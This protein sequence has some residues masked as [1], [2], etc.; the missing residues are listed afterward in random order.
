M[1][2]CAILTLFYLFITGIIFCLAACFFSQ[3]F[4]ELMICLYQMGNYFS[5]KV[6]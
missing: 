5:I 4:Q 1:S 6:S 3:I 2:K